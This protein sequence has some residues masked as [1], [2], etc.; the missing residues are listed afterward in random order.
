MSYLAI[1]DIAIAVYFAVHA[2]RG[3][4]NM[5]WVFILFM[6]PGLGSLVYFFVEYLPELRNSHRAV[7]S[8]R[9][10]KS[11][12]DPNRELRAAREAFERTPT[13]DNRARLAEALLARGDALGAV[14]ASAVELEEVVEQVKISMETTL[15][16]TGTTLS[17]DP[18]PKVMGNYSELGEVFA[19]L[20]DNAI[21]YRSPEV[22]PQI[23][24]TSQI[25]SE[26][27]VDIVVTDKAAVLCRPPEKLWDVVKA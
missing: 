19:N 4:R 10:V 7:K 15:A 24:V 26:G 1:A 2:L 5:Y 13:V 27:M 21:K 3:G 25:H 16:V 11:I 8:V 12:V 6:F 14:D 23:R 20:F 17:I 22:A 18:L 9:A